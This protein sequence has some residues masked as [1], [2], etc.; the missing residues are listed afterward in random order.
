MRNAFGTGTHEAQLETI[1]ERLHCDD[2][3]PLFSQRRTEAGCVLQ[4][5]D[6]TLCLRNTTGGLMGCSNE[7]EMFMIEFYKTVKA[8]NM[9]QYF[10]A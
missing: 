8:W 6:G 10:G 7:P 2:D 1:R 5:W 3:F 9:E 4:C